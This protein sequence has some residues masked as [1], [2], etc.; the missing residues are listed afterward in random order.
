MARKTLDG[1]ETDTP[2]KVRPIRAATHW[3]E[4]RA[5]GFI[6]RPT[7]LSLIGRRLCD[8][9]GERLFS[10]LPSPHVVSG[11]NSWSCNGVR[12]VDAGKRAACRNGGF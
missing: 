10:R 6:T 4:P 2:N 8:N 7:N 11:P 3:D 1:I 12:H 9:G 5:A